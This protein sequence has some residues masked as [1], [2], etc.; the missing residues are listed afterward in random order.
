LAGANEEDGEGLKRQG[1]KVA[2]EFEGKFEI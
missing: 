1:A 2:K